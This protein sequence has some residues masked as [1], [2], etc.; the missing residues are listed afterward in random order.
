LPRPAA[1][2]CALLAVLLLSA[3]ATGLP[4]AA[5]DALIPEA[6]T[7][8]VTDGAGVLSPEAA[9]A[10]NTRLEQFEKETS[11]QILVWTAKRIPGGMDIADFGVRTGRKWGVGQADRRNGVVLFVFSEDRKARIE[12]GYG[13][14]G[15]IPDAIAKRILDEQAIPHFRDGDYAA[16]ITAAADGIMAAAKGEYKGTGTTVAERKGR[17]RKQKNDLWIGCLFFT[18]FFLLPLIFQ[19]RRGWR[20]YRK[21]GWSSGP[22]FVG[23]GGGGSGGGWSSGGWSGGGGFG[24]GGG[25]FSGGGGSFGGGGASGSW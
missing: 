1:F 8:Y 13:L 14:E 9:S 3:A 10:L 17:G 2:R 24:G 5:S 18:L 21:G 25:G 4:Q 7:R 15:V 23:W 16:G 12:V 11:N 6:P 22:W 19:M 20:N